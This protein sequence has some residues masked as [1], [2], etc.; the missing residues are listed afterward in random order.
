MGSIP[1]GNQIFSLS[2]AHVMLISSLFPFHYGAQNSPSLFTCH[3][4]VYHINLGKHN[5]V[6]VLIEFTGQLSTGMF[7]DEVT[8]MCLYLEACEAVYLKQI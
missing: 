8:W 4:C 7:R 1:V 5:S 6:V 2:H 3:S